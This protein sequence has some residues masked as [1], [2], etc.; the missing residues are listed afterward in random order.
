MKRTTWILLLLLII[1]IGV[2]YLLNHLPEKELTDSTVTP[3]TS[4]YLFRETDSTLTAIRIF[5]SAGDVIALKRNAEAAWEITFPVSS[6]ADQTKLSAAETQLNALKFVTNIGI[7]TSLV[8]FGL[9][10]P[11]SNIIL[12]Y[13]N[14]KIH[15]L[16]IGNLSPTNSGYYV[17]LDNAGVF[18][19]SQYSLDAIL[20]LA[21]NP[22]FPSTPTPSPTVGL[23]I[24]TPTNEILPSPSATMESTP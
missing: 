24:Y 11:K 3:D 14:G 18:I 19:V 4:A 23:P 9:A 17:Q 1:T 16:K 21:T 2:Y 13:S 6:E 15:H 7:V 20:E 10:V 5:N 8:D 12:D 22:P